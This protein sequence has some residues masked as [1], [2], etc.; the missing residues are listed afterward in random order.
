MQ[1][2][3]VSHPGMRARTKRSQVGIK[4]KNND[5]SMTMETNGRNKPKQISPTISFYSGK[6]EREI[7]K[8]EKQLKSFE[9]FD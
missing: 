5:S 2:P 9:N 6:R 3:G 1:K 7:E 4:N 8:V